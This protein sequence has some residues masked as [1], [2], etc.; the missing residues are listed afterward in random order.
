MIV[1]PAV[2]I[3]LELG[4]PK[5]DNIRYVA[6]GFHP[7]LRG[8][9]IILGPPVLLLILRSLARRIGKSDTKHSQVEDA[10]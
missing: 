6:I 9:A 1:V 3:W 10:E 4:L 8:E 2:G 7:T 5:V